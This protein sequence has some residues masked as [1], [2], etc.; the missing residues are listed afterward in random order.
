MKVFACQGCGTCCYGEGG[1]VLAPGESHRIAGYLGIPEETFLAGYTEKRLG[2]LSIRTG[3]DG[4][5]LFYDAVRKCTIHPV[6]PARCALWPFFPAI[7]ADR[8]EWEMAKTACPGINPEASFEEFGREA[9]R[10]PS[11]TEAD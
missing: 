5:C 7:V 6:K 4:W 2:R 10:P 8:A 11:E 1:I 3:E 9:E